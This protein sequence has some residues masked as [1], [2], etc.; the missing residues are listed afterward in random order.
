VNQPILPS[1]FLVQLDHLLGLLRIFLHK[2]GGLP[3]FSSH[4]EQMPQVRPKRLGN[5][6]G[7]S[8][9]FPQGSVA[10]KLAVGDVILV[11][12]VFGVAVDVMQP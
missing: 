3:Q 1:I 11:M 4:I 2:V 10:E 9:L 8:R 5:E 12:N 7:C 6:Y